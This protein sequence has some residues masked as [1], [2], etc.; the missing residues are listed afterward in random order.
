MKIYYK[1]NFHFIQ[2]AYKIQVKNRTFE[3]RHRLV[4]ASPVAP[5]PLVLFPFERQRLL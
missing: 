2:I 5:P 4:G 1:S 3:R